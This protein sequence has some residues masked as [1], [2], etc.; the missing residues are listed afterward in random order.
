M[1]PPYIILF[2]LALLSHTAFTSSTPNT[3]TLPL[4][5]L[6]TKSPSSDPFHSLKLA[7]ST[8]LTRAHHLKHRN[9]PPSLVTTP[10]YPK[11]YGGYSIDLSFG[12]PP[13]TS[14]F[15]LD[16]GSSLVWFPCTSRYLCSH[17]LFPHI[18]PT[19]I[20]TFIPKNSSTA[21]LLG[22][23]NPKCGY[24]FGPDVQSRCPQC[25]PVSQN[26]SLTCP[27]YIIQY[28][29]G[30]TAGFLLLDNLDFP[31]KTVPDILVG[32][33][34]LSIRQPSGIAGFGRGQESLPSQMGLKRFSYCLVSHRF[35]DSPENSD[36]VLQISSTGGAKT[37]GLSYTPFRPNPSANNSAFREYYYVTLRKVIVGGQRVKIPFKFL[38]P[39]SEGN[40]GAIVD[41][42]S[43]FT[44]MERAVYDLVAQEFVKQ[45]GNYSRAKDVE[46]QSG[47][48]PCF[49]VSSLATVSFPELDFSVQRRRQNDVAGCE[50]FL[51]GRRF[52]G[53]VSDRCLRR[54]CRSGEDHRSGHH[55]GELSAAEFLR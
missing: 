35:D 38:E 1:A 19:K 40:G 13:Q 50:L 18:D 53:A 2:L 12:T 32:C 7:A 36:L 31:G 33:S 48:S 26:C 52:G 24:L 39:D 22:C 41:S 29:S 34:I 30:S 6:L 42:G 21:K 54:R 16:T 10:V 20:P 9:T 15:V 11:G 49:N 17:C 51:A 55:L 28:G 5:P 45:L 37:D 46:A 27:P 23:R 43:T 4:S 14:P 3:I 44:F 8:S 25:N 47:L